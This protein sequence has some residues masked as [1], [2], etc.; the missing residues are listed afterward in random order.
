MTLG[1]R[2][3]TNM[4]ALC[5]HQLMSECFFPALENVKGEVRGWATLRKYSETF[6]RSKAASYCS[7][8]TARQLLLGSRIHATYNQILHK[9]A[10]INLT[11]LWLCACVLL[12]CVY[13]CSG[14]LTLRQPPFPAAKQSWEKQRSGQ[15]R[16]LK[17]WG[18]IELRPNGLKWLPAGFLVDSYN[19]TGETNSLLWVF[20]LT[21]AGGDVSMR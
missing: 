13:R 19:V 3:N 12:L 17:T 16:E 11:V 2:F 14:S 7:T 21:S 6:T 5:F 4:F 18:N 10:L 1:C 8:V 20:V 15:K 9:P